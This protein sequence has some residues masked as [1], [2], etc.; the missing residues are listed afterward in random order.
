MGLHPQPSMAATQHHHPLLTWPLAKSSFSLLFAS[1][2]PLLKIARTDS[3]DPSYQ[4]GQA[5]I[6]C[7]LI[8][9]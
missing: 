9:N 4:R 8:K 7:F 2:Q 1:P 5:L 3:P 6:Y